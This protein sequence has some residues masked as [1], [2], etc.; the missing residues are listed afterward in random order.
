MLLDFVLKFHA[1]STSRPEAESVAAGDALTEEAEKII[2]IQREQGTF[3]LFFGM[4]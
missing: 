1:W 4:P 3:L 2:Q